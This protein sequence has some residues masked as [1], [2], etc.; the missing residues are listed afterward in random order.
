MAGGIKRAAAV[1]AIMLLPAIVNAGNRVKLLPSDSLVAGHDVQLPFRLEAT[2]AALANNGSA[3]IG[4][5]RWGVAWQGV[6]SEGRIVVGWGNTDFGSI[7]DS[8]FLRV[9]VE[10]GDS[11]IECADITES[12]DLYKGLNTL[13]VVLE[14]SGLVKWSI[15]ST[16]LGGVGSVQLPAPGNKATVWLFSEGRGVNV[17]SL[18]LTHLTDYHVML[19]TP[20]T[21]QEDFP[22]ASSPSTTPEGVWHYLDRDTDA[23]WARPGGRYTL[24]IRKSTDTDGWDIIYLDGAVTNA[25]QW[26]PGMLKGA[27]ESMPFVRHFNL[28][29]IDALF[30]RLDSSD[31]CSASLNDDGS[32]LTLFF[33]LDRSTLR[34]YRLKEP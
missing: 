15:G 31:E 21:R 25:S 10:S 13:S 22:A 20:Y 7:T 23:K 11:I 9:Q 14:P 8:R 4:K 16:A 24:G 5:T 29:W 2:C 28:K 26:Q 3:G 1:I 34:F 6:E 27:L 33:P 19:Q 17:E 18:S 12:V 30:D 32:I